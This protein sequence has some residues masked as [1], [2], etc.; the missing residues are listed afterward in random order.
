MRIFYDTE[1][2]PNCYLLCAEDEFGNRSQF[3]IS[4]WK[5]EALALCEWIYAQ[6][7]VG[8]E[9]VG[10]NNIGFD[11]PILH[12]ILSGVSSPA[13]IYDKC[14]AIINSQDN[15]R[16][17]HLVKP[18]DY[19]IPQIDL[20][21]IHHFDNKA[22]TT[23]LKAL[24]FNMRLPNISDLPFPPG[25]VLQQ[26]QVKVLRD[27]CF[28]DVAATRKFYELSL[29]KIEFREVL[30]KKYGRSFINHNDVKIGK[31]IFQIALEAAGVK[32][33]TFG[34]DG[35]QPIQTK[36][37]SIN[38]GDCVPNFIRLNHPEFRKVKEY[39]KTTVITQTKGA[40]KLT[41]TVGNLDFHFGTG[42]IH[43]SVENESFEEDDAMM[44]YDVDVTSLYPSIA[45]EH[46]FYPEHL[47][48]TFVQVY[49]D[50][51]TQRLSHP[52]NSPENAMLKLALN[53]VY[54]ASSDP[55][56]IF[57]DPLFTMKITV[58]GQLM[59]AMLAERLTEVE[60]VKIIQANTDGISLFM[61]RR[62]KLTVDMVCAAWEQLT[63]M[64]LEYVEYSRMIVADVNSYIA[65]KKDGSTKRKGRYEHELEWHKD[66]SALVVPKI[67]EQVLLHGG[68]IMDRLLNWPDKFDF[69]LRVK[70]TKGTTLVLSAGIDLPLD[71]TQRYYVSEYGYEMFKIMPPLKKNPDVW[72]RIAVQKGYFVC[73][74]NDI[75]DS[76][77]PVDYSW[78]VNEIEKLILGVL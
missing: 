43:A 76:V 55:F 46:G 36:R 40:F 8:S 5:N 66:G 71:R 42:G 9:M 53:G 6:N 50:L 49:R 62:V 44:I 25:T 38:L 28:D 69:M 58:A 45:I 37:H 34:E 56:S 19:R 26:S 15:D 27:Y 17:R 41:A 13:Y 57:Y 12:L 77:M 7:S 64:S 1:V 48:P 21:K 31:E 29:P 63:K 68:S 52:K 2:F 59:I 14:Q 23:S 61:P 30:G 74:C 35:R 70:A 20:F 39:F 11:Y 4:V 3:E 75:F 51:R 60:G 72:R 24:E 33:F 47:G 18:S 16:F 22:R 32:C 54:G 10:F 73:P 78:Y 65:V 67:A